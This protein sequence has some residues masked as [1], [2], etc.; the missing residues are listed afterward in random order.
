MEKVVE[1]RP[2]FVAGWQNLGQLYCD[3]G[4]WERA[5]KAFRSAIE[6]DNDN[7]LAHFNLAKVLRAVGKTIEADEEM[8]LAIKLDP[9]LARYERR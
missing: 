1:Q 7:A 8:R 3:I 9:R 6:L 2:D 4:D 5:E